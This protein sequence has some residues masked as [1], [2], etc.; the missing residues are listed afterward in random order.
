MPN[1]MSASPFSCNLGQ[2]VSFAQ[3][4]IQH[5]ST[6]MLTCRQAAHKKKGRDPPA[7]FARRKP[8]PGFQITGGQG[9]GLEV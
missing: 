2:N 1:K 9:E 6:E 3:L 5:K 4:L 8:T 7:E